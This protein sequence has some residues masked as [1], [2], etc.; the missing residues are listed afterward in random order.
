MRA[1]TQLPGTTEYPQLAEIGDERRAATVV[2]DHMGPLFASGE[3]DV[4]RVSVER[5]YYTPGRSDYRLK[6]RAGVIARD[7]R[8]MGEQ[9]FCGQ[10]WPRPT[11]ASRADE[12]RDRTLC[13]P[14][15]GQPLAIVE[16]WSLLLWAFPNDPELPKLPDLAQLEMLLPR[17]RAHPERFGL[18]ADAELDGLSAT[19]VKYVPARRCTWRFEI[20]LKRGPAGGGGTHGFYG[21]A[22][23]PR[24]GQ[25]AYAVQRA[26]WDGMPRGGALRIAETY[27]FDS[28]LDAM[29][30]QRLPG[31][32][33]TQLLRDAR[34]PTL[35]ANAGRS[36]AALHA[37]RAELPERRTL[38][39]ELA[40]LVEKGD[41]ILQAF[42]ER[43][44]RCSALRDQLVAAADG[45]GAGSRTI[46]HGAFRLSHVLCD[47][48]EVALIDLDGACLGDPA[49]D[50][51]RFVAHLVEARI[52]GRA[53]ERLA[54]DAEQAFVSAYAEACNEPVS[55]ERVRW[56]TAS[57]LVT[58]DL[59]KSVKRRESP[60]FDAVLAEAEALAAAGGGARRSGRR[61]SPSQPPAGLREPASGRREPPAGHREPPTGRGIP[62]DA[63]LPELA[64]LVD[65]ERMRGLF[66]RQVMDTSTGSGTDTGGSRIAAAEL[67]KVNYRIGRYCGALYR[68]RFEQ[69]AALSATRW[70]Y[71]RHA[72]ATESRE[73]FEA[74]RSAA[75]PGE[76]TYWSE[77]DMIVWAFPGDPRMRQLRELVEPASLRALV[78]QERAALG[79]APG[80]PIERLSMDPIKHMPGKRTVL[81]LEIDV[82]GD[83]GRQLRVFSKSYRDARSRRVYRA[84]EATRDAL[85]A[86]GARLELPRPLVYLDRLHTYWQL[87]WPGE[88]MSALHGS[89]RMDGALP[90]V[91][92]SLGELHDCAPTGLELA[93]YVGETA[94]GAAEDARKISRY[95]PAAA[96]R[97]QDLAERLARLEPTLP[98]AASFPQATL[99][100]AFRMSQLLQRGDRLAVVDYDALARG[101]A[102]YDVAEFHASLLFQVFRRDLDLARVGRQADTFRS[103][104]EK[105]TG[106][107]LDDARL[108]WF[109]AAFLLEKLYLTL[110]SL[111]VRLHA[112]I[113]EILELASASL[114]RVAAR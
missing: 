11:L 86:N 21:K 109:E 19:L 40:E 80:E 60:H 32:P 25:R 97:A 61:S 111:D 107:S 78:E 68:L 83:R 108:A 88:S 34:L 9:V 46:V 23:R 103:E 71:V 51:G 24:D 48:V 37:T 76:V 35:A 47:D 92:G 70:Y 105:Q 6:L 28:E 95:W 1:Q 2:R 77:Q 18:S 50:L 54:R 114:D 52:S 42:P 81:R 89:S 27:G 20:R 112:R 41:G 90:L 33:L 64:R 82:G 102:H 73:R 110:K 26:I 5:A 87:E 84:L 91:A 101:D 57:H 62:P 96:A 14:G 39:R 100:G 49:H 104:Y 85:A 55:E 12:A 58:G 66:Q 113:D 22:Y 63:A 16:P 56:F 10:L 44:A 45:L 30:Q 98:P 79:I 59:Y 38:D 3:L 53:D 93:D 7:G 31:Q 17:V 8:S 4:D 75:G 29:F 99:H 13:E 36:L 94:A 65:P 106:R 67:E 74:A 72:P 15:F 69:A 43:A